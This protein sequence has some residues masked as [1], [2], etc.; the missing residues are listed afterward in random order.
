MF[1][2]ATLCSLPSLA[3]LECNAKRL[4]GHVPAL[5]WSCHCS[6]FHLATGQLISFHFSSRQRL[7]F[8]PK[9]LR[10][11]GNTLKVVVQHLGCVTASDVNRKQI[12]TFKSLTSSWLATLRLVP[13]FSLLLLW[14]TLFRED[15]I[16]TFVL[17]NF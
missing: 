3:L 5:F 16:F 17:F 1:G 12:K 15:N 13:D 6:S 2:S 7:T 9:R 14:K 11:E 4:C 8:G 10:P